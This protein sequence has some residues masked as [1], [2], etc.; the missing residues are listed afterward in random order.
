MAVERTAGDRGLNDVA[1]GAAVGRIYRSECL[2]RGVRPAGP[3]TSAV[4]T[5]SH[6]T[7]W[8]RGALQ[9]APP[10]RRRVQGQG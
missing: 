9:Q 2:H 1:D 6:I 8:H 10:A 5:V 4:T 3:T 7:D